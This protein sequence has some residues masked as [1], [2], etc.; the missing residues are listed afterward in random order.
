MD[1]EELRHAGRVLAGLA[2]A[3]LE[4]APEHPDLLVGRADR[5]HPVREPAGLLRVD[6]A[7]GRDVDRHGRL[8]A[9]VQAQRLQPEVIPAVPHDLAGEEPVD[10]LDRL[11]QHRAADADLRP[12]ATDHVLVERLAGA[13]AEPEAA[14][15]HGPHR[16]RR[17]RD[18]GRVVAEAGAG[19]GGPE[20]QA[21][22]LPERAHERPGEGRLPLL[23]RP[24]LDVLGN[25]EAGREARPFRR[26]TPLEQVPGM[27]LLQHRRVADLRHGFGVL[28]P[29]GRRP[30]GRAVRRHHCPTIRR[31]K[32]P[33]ADRGLS[34]VRLLGR[35]RSRGACAGRRAR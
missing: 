5:D 16:G 6:R 17:V 30:R 28:L 27:E 13:K 11:E 3:L 12:L 7:G 34:P 32:G 9:R 14:R 29:T 20:P 10:D 2:G 25:H 4:L 18:H 35:R 22:A 19:H 31:G 15:V 23:R 24:R 1:L 8:R 21:R 33:V 26:G